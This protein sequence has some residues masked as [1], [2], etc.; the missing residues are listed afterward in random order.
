VTGYEKEEINSISGQGLGL[1][2]LY[3]DRLKE[4]KEYHRKFP[5]LMPE[6]PEDILPNQ[7]E[8]NINFTGEEGSGKFLDLHEFYIGFINLQMNLNVKKMQ[9]S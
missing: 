7:E 5:N 3:Y 2:S 6:R 8:L 9:R 1:Y 4:L